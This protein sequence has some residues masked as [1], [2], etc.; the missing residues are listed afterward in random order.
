V[1][2]NGPWSID[3]LKSYLDQR[4]K[5]VEDRAILRAEAVANQTVEVKSQQ[6]LAREIFNQ[7]AIRADKE[8]EKLSKFVSTESFAAISG[9]FIKELDDLRNEL[10][11]AD[12][13]ITEVQS[14]LSDELGKIRVD[15]LGKEAFNTFVAHNDADLSD[16]RSDFKEAELHIAQIRESAYMRVEQKEFSDRL[17]NRISFMDTERHRIE[18]S[19]VPRS[20]V[21]IK[22]K[23]TDQHFDRIEEAFTEFRAPKYGLWI[24]FAVA[25]FIALSG[26]YAVVIRP[27]ETQLEAAQKDIIDQAK[28]SATGESQINKL[29]ELLKQHMSEHEK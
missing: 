26:V 5:D 19:L 7:F 9:R 8:F 1:D 18:T 21:D 6:L 12:R 27:L 24:S 29:E 23:S 17:D 4:L 11:E 14:K 22:W 15:I 2:A 28:A 16:I 13:R 20:E 3:A 10:H 25:T